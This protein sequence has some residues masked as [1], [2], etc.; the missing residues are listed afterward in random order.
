MEI[1]TKDITDVIKEWIEDGNLER[2]RNFENLYH[3]FDDSEDGNTVLH[4]AIKRK[5]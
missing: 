3:M 2:L 4:F 1:E 5:K